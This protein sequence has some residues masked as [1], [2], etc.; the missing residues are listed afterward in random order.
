MRRL[1]L[2]LLLLGTAGCPGLGQVAFSVDSQ[3][4]STFQGNPAGGFLSVFPAF[5]G[6][7]NLTFKQN[8]SFQNNNT[9]KDHVAEARLTKLTLKIVTPTNATLNFLSTVEFDIGAPGLPTIRIAEATI[10]ANV[11]TIDLTLDPQ[12]I[13][14]YAKAD[15][16]SITTQGTGHQP[17]TDTTV[18]ADLSIRIVA[19]VL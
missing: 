8:Q 15:T 14:P 16:F 5:G 9:N 3:G 6:F 17:T 18:E 12:D 11:A 7:G 13:A 10:P 4:Q 1:T 2:V 19:N